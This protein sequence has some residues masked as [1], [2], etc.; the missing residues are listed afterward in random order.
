MS[1][2]RAWRFLLTAWVAL[3]GQVACQEHEFEPPSQAE[4]VEEADRRFDT[5][6]FDTVSWP[7]EAVRVREGNAVYAAECRKCHGTVGQGATEYAIANGLD[8]PSLVEPD[9]DL[10]D[11]PLALR[12]RIYTGHEK[13]MPT[14]GIAGISPREIDAVAAYLTED[15]RP[16]VLEERG[17]ETEETP[18]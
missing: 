12:H 3:F 8:V 6:L 18:R 10:A 17:G 4:R 1:P 13:G 5:A 11:D 9:W 15:L 2:D 16:E 7:D 14:W